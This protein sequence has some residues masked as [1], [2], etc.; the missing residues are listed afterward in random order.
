MNSQNRPLRSEL[1]LVKFVDITIANLANYF[2]SLNPQ[3]KERDFLEE[4]LNVVWC[5]DDASKEVP[6]EIVSAVIDDPDNAAKSPLS[7]M[8]LSCVYCA[9]AMKAYERGESDTAWSYMADAR[10]WCGAMLS[11]KSVDK[12]YANTV[13][14]TGKDHARSGGIAKAKKKYEKTIAEAHRLAREKR[15]QQ[16]GWRSRSQAARAIKDD[17]LKF[18]ETEKNAKPLKTTQI[19]KTLDDWL[20]KMPD[21]TALFSE[22]RKKKQ[23]HES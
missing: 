17:I 7:T 20:R 23:D 3:K 19:M 8:I 10:F 13:I 4:I 12:E 5:A 14:Q 2:I 21:A 6:I 9:R 22:N 18:S 16:N 1:T 11:N 15:P